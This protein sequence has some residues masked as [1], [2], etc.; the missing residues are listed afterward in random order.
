ML[1]PLFLNLTGRRVLLVG[2]GPVAAAKLQQLLAAS[3]AGPRRSAARA[4]RHDAVANAAPREV[5]R[6]FTCAMREVPWAPG[7]D[8]WPQNGTF[9]ACSSISLR[10]TAS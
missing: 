3:A 9:P 6:A 10:S 2:G 7:P 1:L 4:H 8:V 5:L